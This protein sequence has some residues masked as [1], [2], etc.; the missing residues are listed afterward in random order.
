MLDRSFP[1][2]RLHQIAMPVD[3][4]HFW[5][6]HKEGDEYCAAHCNPV[7]FAELMQDGKWVF[8]SSAAEQANAWIGGFL[9]I[10]REMRAERYNFFL[11]EMIRRRNEWLFEELEQKG[12]EPRYLDYNVVLRSILVDEELA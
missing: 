12:Q 7:N 6:K 5:C 3:V 11:D 1:D 2:D 9:A 10:V 4:F 8:N